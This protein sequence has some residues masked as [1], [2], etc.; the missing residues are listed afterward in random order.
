M[1]E[2]HKG[3]SSYC[4][5]ETR[6]QRKIGRTYRYLMLRYVEKVSEREEKAGTGFERTEKKYAG[7]KT[8]PLRI[9]SYDISIRPGA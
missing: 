8:L 6:R 2:F 1:A 5:A 3:K 7:L 9:R 4:A